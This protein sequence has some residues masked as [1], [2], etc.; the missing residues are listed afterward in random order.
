MA[1]AELAQF[2]LTAQ[3][4]VDRLPVLMQ[5]ADLQRAVNEEFD[6]CRHAQRYRLGSAL[7]R[8]SAAIG[9]MCDL[10]QDVLHPALEVT[11]VGAWPA[12][13]HAQ[14]DTAVLRELAAAAPRTSEAQHSA[15]VTLLEAMVQLQLAGLDDLLA[16]V[17]V[18]RVPWGTLAAQMQAL[19]KAWPLR[20]G[21]REAA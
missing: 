10:Q 4:L 8:L 9:L 13:Q 11:R 18:T 15:L 21:M 7:R 2:P 5:L 6:A 1:S 14:R 16:Q 20:P 19:L 12:L 3:G 17:D